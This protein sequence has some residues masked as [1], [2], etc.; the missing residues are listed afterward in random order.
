M[1]EK[2][3]QPLQKEPPKDQKAASEGLRDD[4]R[5]RNGIEREEMHRQGGNRVSDMNGGKGKA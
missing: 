2:Q 4:V 1:S 5:V 3:K